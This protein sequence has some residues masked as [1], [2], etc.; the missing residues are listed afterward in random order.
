MKKCVVIYFIINGSLVDLFKGDLLF[1]FH[2][3]W[4]IEFYV[5]KHI[6]IQI[7]SMLFGFVYNLKQVYAIFSKIDY[8]ASRYIAIFATGEKRYVTQDR[9][10]SIIIQHA[11]EKTV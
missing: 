3:R 9:N 5:N 1:W 2:L 4:P 8:V 10:S 7:K 6:I 11:L